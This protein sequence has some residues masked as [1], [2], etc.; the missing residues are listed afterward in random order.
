VDFILSCRAMGRKIEETMLHVAVASARAVK[1]K[2]LQAEYVPTSKNQPC[3]AFFENSDFAKVDGA[4]TYGWNAERPY[5]K[6]AFLKL[7]MRSKN[8]L[9]NRNEEMLK[10]AYA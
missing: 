3:L 4:T 9:Q 1:A 5:S 7:T 2:S 6:P 10:V 8:G